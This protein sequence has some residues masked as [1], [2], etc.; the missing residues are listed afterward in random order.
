LCIEV[1]DKSRLFVDLTDPSNSTIEK[2]KDTTITEIPFQASV[3]VDAA[4]ID[5]S[6]RHQI[7]VGLFF[8]KLGT[9]LGM[10]VYLDLP[11]YRADFEK[12]QNVDETCT[13][14][15]SSQSKDKEIAQKVLTDAYRIKPSVNWQVGMVAEY[16]VSR[17]TLQVSNLLTSIKV[18]WAGGKSN[19]PF[20]NGT[21]SNLTNSCLQFNKTSG[22]YVDAKQ[23]VAD[24]KKNGAAGL[25][26]TSTTSLL[27]FLAVAVALLL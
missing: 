15:A 7:Q 5:V 26:A 8:S 13:D 3:D 6:L 21:F 23:L 27:A 4:T 16:E 10:G 19:I 17:P 22:T 9:N 25:V 18:F 14:L 20:D 11:K 12:V 24:T 1:P 2:F